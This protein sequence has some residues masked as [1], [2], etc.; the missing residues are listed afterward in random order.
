MFDETAVKKIK[1]AES[2]GRVVYVM[3]SQSLLDYMYFQWVLSK[4]G[5]PLPGIANGMGFGSALFLRPF[6]QIITFFFD[7]L[8]GRVRLAGP[9]DGALER[10]LHEGKAAL[11]FMRP[12]RSVLPTAPAEHSGM[13]EE[14]VAVQEKSDVPIILL[15]QFLL[16][17]R[18]SDR[19]NRSI[20]DMV[21]G[22]PDAPGRLRKL[23][24]FI[25]NHRRAFVH[26]GDSLNLS[27]FI[28]EHQDTLQQGDHALAVK[29]RWRLHHQFALEYRV[30][31][32]PVVKDAKRMRKEIMRHPEFIA[33]VERSAQI[34]GK[35][36][37]AALK[38]VDKY[39]A[40]MAAD[41]TM[42]A[43]EILCMILALIW[44]RLYEG[45]EVEE[46]GLERLRQV[47]KKAPL[48]IVPTHRS[49]V[50]YL[51]ISYV[52]YNR[53][54]I[55]P[56]IAAGINLSFFPL[57]HIFRRC[58]AFFIRRTF[59]DNPLYALTFRYYLRKLIKEGHWIEF[60]PEGGRSRTGKV[61]PPKLG[62]LGELL[63]AVRDGVREDLYF[64]PVSIS[65][66]KVVE[67]GVY[68]R[69]L[70]GAEKSSESVGGVLKA[71][72]VLVTKHGRLSLRFAEPVST[73]D[74]LNSFDDTGLSK[75]E[76]HAQQLRVFG[77]TLMRGMNDAAIVTPSSLL[78]MVMLA[79]PR[80]GISRSQLLLRTGYLMVYLQRKG[81]FKSGTLRSILEAASHQLDNLPIH[82]AEEASPFGSLPRG[83]DLARARIL[84]RALENVVDETLRHFQRDNA[85]QVTDYGD[86][87]AYSVKQESRSALDFYKNNIL[88]LVSEEGILST[89]LLSAR[90]ASVSYERLREL[91]LFLS[92]LFKLELVYQPG[93]SF[94]IS[95][96]RMLG[97]FVDAGW[98]AENEDGSFT[99]HRDSDEL[100]V[101]FANCL[102]PYVEGYWLAL[103]H[104]ERLRNGPQPER[105]WTRTLHRRA[106]K[107][108]QDEVI[109][110]PEASSSVTFKHALDVFA[111]MNLVD[112]YREESL[113]K[114]GKKP[115]MERMLG[116]DLEHLDRIAAILPD[117]EHARAL[118]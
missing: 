2:L 52:F 9:H 105:E 38:E 6:G 87:V 41:F 36:S 59:R 86:E 114:G 111:S 30:L 116:V 29:M 42:G 23:I 96:F 90:G 1:E 117:L 49:H 101:F 63:D 70:S 78:A 99:V 76:C 10:T 19:Y 118:K 69:E 50:D 97:R 98:I 100:V 92:R 47:A 64:C 48:V 20:V 103:T 53:G 74:F 57:G 67:E 109:R 72:K 51:V 39:L 15:P 107:L 79:H 91:S 80:T 7:W 4:N 82:A 55:P 45:I 21:F 110:C 3:K 37:G 13:L 56:H 66:E 75:E 112:R 28:A 17:K 46:A 68:S 44:N 11:V 102:Q 31:K 95:Y 113:K 93:E 43:V 54:L 32:G 16:W 81:S 84:A 8:V 61:L 85:V 88:H 94:D 73:R 27:E 77:Y 22:H 12:G 60:F 71:T 25:L 89:A 115:R 65:Y 35:D 58:G 18:S 34:L 83:E 24:N 62:M 14:L 108:A 104:L 26:V 33:E 40:E 5:L 106:E